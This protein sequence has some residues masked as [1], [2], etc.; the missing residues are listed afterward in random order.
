[1]RPLRW[2]PARI[3]KVD[4]IPVLEIALVFLASEFAERGLSLLYR[5]LAL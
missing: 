5:R 1:V 4:F 3:G 2:L